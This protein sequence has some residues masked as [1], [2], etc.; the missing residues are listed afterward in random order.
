MPYAKVNLFPE[1]VCV[2]LP[3]SAD[4]VAL[5]TFARCCG[6]TAAHCRPEGHAAIDQY[7]PQA[8]SIQPTRAA[9]GGQMGQRQTDGYKTVL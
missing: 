9:C 1:Q 6:T 3:A 8:H 2:Q 4:N 7:R 5:P